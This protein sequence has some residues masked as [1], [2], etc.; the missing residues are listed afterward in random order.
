MPILACIAG[1]ALILVVLWDAFETIVLPR[2]VTRRV[3]LT[4]L[5][6]RF[7]WAP[8]RA[9]ARRMRKTP[10]R[11]GFL[12]VFGPLVLFALLGIWAILLVL[13]FALIQWGLGSKMT[14]PYGHP[15]FGT[16][17]YM[18]GTTFI[19][20]GLGDV[21][22]RTSEARALTV[23]EAGTGFGFLALMLS[24][25]PV[26]F[27][28]FSRRE[29]NI[30]LLDARAGSPRSAWSCCDGQARA[31][32]PRRWTPSCSIGN[33]GAGSCW[34]VTFPIRALPTSAPSTTTDPGCGA[35]RDHGLLLIDS[36]R[37]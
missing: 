27:T 11:E 6:Y 36:R 16:D 34:K 33:A 9:L 18:S 21:A 5:I 35:D 30:S 25:L 26:L 10:R 19:T 17:L 24:Y 29:V 37:R 7:T 32:R 15:G 8:W 12:S 28:A 14:V 3:R 2:R 4:R 31:T 22:P 23:I 20:L 1:I 13:G